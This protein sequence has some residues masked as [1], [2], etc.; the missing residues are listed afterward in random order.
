MLATTGIQV[1]PAHSTAPSPSSSAPW[2][3]QRVRARL[4]A[5][6]LRCPSSASLIWSGGRVA[7]RRDWVGT[8]AI[9]HDAPQHP[10]PRLAGRAGGRAE[11]SAAPRGL[12]D[13]PRGPSRPRVVRG[14]RAPRPV[15]RG[16]RTSSLGPSG[17]CGRPAGRMVRAAGGRKAHREP[18]GVSLPSPAARQRP[19][20]PGWSAP[21]C[22]CSGRWSWRSTRCPASRCRRWSR[23]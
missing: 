13:H 18:V 11:P 20:Q 10:G 21:T 7:P 16:A 6:R 5:I 23:R 2:L 17:R 1:P 4:N 8:S 14:G 22:C 15:G 19:D 9:R 3:P 12:P